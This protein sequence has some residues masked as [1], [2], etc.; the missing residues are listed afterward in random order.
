M[1]VKTEHSVYS[2]LM[3]ILPYSLVL[4]IFIF[5]ISNGA[6]AHECHGD[7]E[8]QANIDAKIDIIRL[9]SGKKNWSDRTVNRNVKYN[10]ND[11]GCH[12]NWRLDGK[13]VYPRGGGHA[14]WDVVFTRDKHHSFYSITR[15]IVVA[16]G[17]GVN[18]TIAIYDPI[19][20]RMVL[21]LHANSVNRRLDVG[22]WIDFKTYLGDQGKKGFA[23]GEHVHIEVRKLTSGQ[24][25]RPFPEQMTRL[26]EAAWGRSDWDRPTIDPIPYLHHSAEWYLEEEEEANACLIWAKFKGGD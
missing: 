11:Y 9:L 2:V 25:N 21:Y 8:I 13:L 5:F 7:D 4:V 22:E 26:T 3:R 6:K 14:G 17:K 23:T 18:N 1:F 15:G 20:E 19:N 12:E 10:G 24:K 16:V